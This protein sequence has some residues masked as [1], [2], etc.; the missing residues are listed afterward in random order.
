MMLIMEAL[1]RGLMVEP[2][3]ATVVL[4]GGVLRHGASAAQRAAIVPGVIAGERILALAHDEV[5]S[6]APVHRDLALV[7]VVGEG[8]LRRSSALVGLVCRVHAFHLSTRF[9]HACAGAGRTRQRGFPS[10]AGSWSRGSESQI[11]SPTS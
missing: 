1:G 10:P 6:E 7:D 2:Y 4:A 11:A 3:F 8:L 9:D 5:Q